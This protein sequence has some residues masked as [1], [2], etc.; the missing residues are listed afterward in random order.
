VPQSLKALARYGGWRMYSGTS[1]QLDRI[2]ADQL[3]NIQRV[4]TIDYIGY[5]IEHGCYLLGDVAMKDGVL[6]KI[7]SE[8]F[9]D[10]GKL[11]IKSL[12]KSVM[13]SINL[14]RDEYRTDWVNLLWTA[15][16]R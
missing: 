15:F 7:N 12:N 5:S 1:N 16:W 10:I 13:L 9:F 14:E 6:T 2:L 3:Y 11:S 8:D 4:E